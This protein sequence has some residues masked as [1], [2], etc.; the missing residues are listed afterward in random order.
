MNYKELKFELDKSVAHKSELIIAALSNIEYDGFIEE[1]YSLIAY[2]TENKFDFEAI[3]QL[4]IILE[5]NDKVK[6]FVND[7]ADTNWNAVWESNFAPVIF[8]NGIIR[9]PFHEKPPLIK[10]DIVIEP[11]MSFGTGHHETTSLMIELMHN[12]DY[13]DKKVL[14]MGCG[15]GV[16]AIYAYMKNAASI[17]AVDNDEWAY[18]NTIENFE[19]N[20]VL[21]A[22]ILLGGIECVEEQKFNI[23]IANITRNILSSMF[24]F[25]EIM[26]KKN[27]KLLISGF[28]EKDTIDM[29]N[30]LKKHKYKDLNI[31]SKNNWVAIELIKI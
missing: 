6:W 28:L 30:L 22:S 8:Q 16:L 20:G 26:Q 11:K 15:T 23:I 25:F 9:A 14:D 18:H 17:V 4:P 21:D 10:Y 3:K 13:A 29:V 12:L 19:R 24:P 2:I 31:L 27:D 1:D 5:L 7:I